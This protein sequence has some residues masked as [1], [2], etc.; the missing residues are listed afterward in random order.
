MKSAF[1]MSKAEGTRP[2]TDEEI[3]FISGGCMPG[4][5]PCEPS[6]TS[7]FTWSGGQRKRDNG[8]GY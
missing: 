6:N 7:G 3:A 5:V 8:P 4:Q 2:L 1:I